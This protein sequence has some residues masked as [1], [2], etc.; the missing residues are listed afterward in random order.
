[1]VWCS[2]SG[3]PEAAVLS[4]TNSS[5]GEGEGGDRAGGEGGEGESEHSVKQSKHS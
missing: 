3:N 2:P 1:M 4:N 5:L